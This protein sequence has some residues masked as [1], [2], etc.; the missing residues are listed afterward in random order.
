[1]TSAHI[2]F[3]PAVLVVGL[4]IGFL[5]GSRVAQDRLN[6]EL[7]RQAEREE[8]FRKRAE[9]KAGSAAPATAE[10]TGSPAAIAANAAPGP[11]S[12]VD[13][14]KAKKKTPPR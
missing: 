7:K 10:S 11:G 6:L 9:R 5:L 14:V 13:T 12:V 2:I 3:I 4:F 8:A 1:M